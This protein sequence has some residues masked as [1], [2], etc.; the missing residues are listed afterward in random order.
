MGK[1]RSGKPKAASL[2]DSRGSAL[3]AN[4][5]AQ[6]RYL[7]AKQAKRASLSRIERPS[8]ANPVTTRYAT[9]WQGDAWRRPD[10]A[11][12][13]VNAILA[14]VQD[15]K[16]RSILSWPKKACD[17]A[18]AAAL[19]L[20]ESRSNGTLAFSTLA[21]W[22]WRPSIGASHGSMGPV[23]NVRVHPE[24]VDL[25]GRRVATDCQ[26]EPPA[27]WTSI[28]GFAHDSTSML[29]LRM[30]ELLR[31]RPDGGHELANSPTLRELTPAFSPTLG[32]D[33][34][35]TYVA[36]PTQVLRR[37]QTYT[38]SA[39]NRLD[40]SPFAARMGNPLITPHAIFGLPL[41]LKEGIHR[42][43]FQFPRFQQSWIDAVVINLTGGNVDLNRDDW[44][45]GLARLLEELL[46]A[47]GRRPPV[48]LLADDPFLF[49]KAESVIRQ[50]A[51]R[52]SR[53]SPIR[54]GV[55]APVHAPIS[56][57]V[58]L[59]S[60]LAPM[61]IKADFKDAGLGS[62]PIKKLAARAEG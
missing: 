4:R 54:S 5:D 50:A 30:K 3:Q 16:D 13:V 17:G 47:P 15:S 1:S 12:P 57:T 11:M 21:V 37:V 23:R 42:Q 58:V 7:I 49:R 45:K 22:P 19:A 18:L 48:V 61:R 59:P 29:E 28:G 40:L 60:T 55:Y 32:A 26:A 10:A 24:D 41:T 9:D 36:E 6:A 56:D 52:A 34:K 2:P 25:V 8:F 20:R 53:Q 31:L 51:G 44:E 46:L 39:R 43:L 27:P 38:Q 62:G 35:L 14:A 33:G